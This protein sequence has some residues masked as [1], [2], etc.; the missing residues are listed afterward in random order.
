M[1]LIYCLLLRANSHG[2]KT[3]T[4]VSEGRHIIIIYAEKGEGVCCKCSKVEIPSRN[5]ILK[6]VD[7][8]PKLKEIGKTKTCSELKTELCCGSLRDN[9]SYIP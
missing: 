4:A 6:S 3:Q 2:T 9:A 1:D 5:R 7:E 8:P